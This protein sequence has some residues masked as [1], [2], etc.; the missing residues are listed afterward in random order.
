MCRRNC[1][2][3]TIIPFEINTKISKIEKELYQTKNRNLLNLDPVSNYEV[4]YGQM[5][6]MGDK[7]MIM[8]M[9]AGFGAEKNKSTK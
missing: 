8:V 7:N 2:N 3:K 1:I 5:G 9:V 6:L 4:P